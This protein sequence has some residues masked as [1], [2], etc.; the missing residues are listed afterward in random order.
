MR[1]GLMVGSDK[2]RNRANR[3]Q[4]LLDD[5]KAA[6]EQ[7]FASFWFPQ[8]PGYLDAMTAVALLGQVTERIEIGTA[9]VPIQTRHPLIMAQQ[10]LTTQASCGGRFTLGLG[11]SHHWIISDQLGLS[12]DKPAKLVRDYL[13]VLAQAFQGPGKVDADNDTYRVHSPVDVTDESVPVLLAALGPTMLKIAGERAGGTILWMADERTIGDYIVPTLTAAANSKAT[14]VVAG[15]PVAL[16]Q[17]HEVPEAKAYASVVLGHADFSPNY[18]RLL[19]HG[20]ADDV[21]DTMAAGNEEQVR[22]RFRRYREAGVTDLAARVVPLGTDPGERRASRE[23]TQAFVA[24]LI[25]DFT[26]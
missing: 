26:S 8:V 13:D 4:G 20:D 2:E 24:S 15:V 9:V 11:P 10:A 19:E 7:G 5:G 25:D 3:L 6:E 17:E 16:C 18:V 21:G 23:R 14:R 1:I 12:Y 22:A